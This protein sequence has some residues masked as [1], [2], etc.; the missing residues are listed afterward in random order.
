MCHQKELDKCPNCTIRL[1]L[2]IM[3]L[4]TFPI[5]KNKENDLTI[6]VTIAYN[7]ELLHF[8]IWGSLASTSIH[9]HKYFFIVLDDHTWFVWIILLKSKYEVSIQVEDF[10][11]I[12]IN[13]FHTTPK[14]VR[15]GNGPELCYNNFMH[16]MV[17][18]TSP[19]R[20]ISPTYPTP[21]PRD[22]EFPRAGPRRINLAQE[23]WLNSCLRDLV[24]NLA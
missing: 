23:V 18:I 3:L 24:L 7:F 2:T 1:N 19:E 14:T 13:L 20:L 9:N 8:D 21:R 5:W 22:L 6:Q 10:I 12:V 17:H 4:M 16:P 15:S 11:T